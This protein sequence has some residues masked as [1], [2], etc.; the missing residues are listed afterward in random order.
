MADAITGLRCQG[1]HLRMGRPLRAPFVRNGRSK[2]QWTLT[3]AAAPWE[4]AKHREA[5]EIS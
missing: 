3:N 5:L 2:S 4:R 1:R